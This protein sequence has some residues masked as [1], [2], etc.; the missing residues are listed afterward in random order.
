MQAV[1]PPSGGAPK[2]ESGETEGES[3]PFGGPSN[4]G[5]SL[6]LMSRRV[7]T[8]LPLDRAGVAT[9]GRGTYVKGFVTKAEIQQSRVYWNLKNGTEMLYGI[10]VRV[11]S[12]ASWF[13]WSGMLLVS[14]YDHSGCKNAAGW[15]PVTHT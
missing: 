9:W 6:S 5:V 1:C 14:Y 8:T 4:L 7:H 2:S 11:L 10:P 15:Y 3:T 12:V 13:H